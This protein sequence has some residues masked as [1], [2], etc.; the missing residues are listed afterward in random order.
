MATTHSREVFRLDGAFFIE[1]AFTRT[2]WQCFW[3]RHLFCWLSLDWSWRFQADA[4]PAAFL[5]SLTTRPTRAANS[6][7][8]PSLDGYAH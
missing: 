2:F 1:R 8:A 7:E 6:A 5:E 3:S 4:A